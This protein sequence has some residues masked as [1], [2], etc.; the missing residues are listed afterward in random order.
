VTATVTTE[1][2]EFQAETKQL[3]DLV[4]HS[5]YTNKD[6]FLR[7]LISNAS[8]ALD[9]VRFESLTNPD[10]LAESETLE[11]RL[12]T[13]IAARRLSVSDNGIGM[14][15]DE[16]I[17]NIGSIAKS[18]TRELTQKLREAKGGAAPLDLIGN[19]GVG[20]YS[21]FMVAD[22]VVVE[23]VRAGESGATRWESRADGT[24]TIGPG[25]RTTRGTTVT[26]YLKP[27]DPE[28]GIQDYT[29]E[30]TLESIVKRYSDFVNYPIRHKITRERRETDEKGIVKP[31]GTTTIVTDDKTLNSQMPIWV[32]SESEVSEDDYD[33][34]YR[35]ISGDWEKPM[36]RFSYKAE[37]V[38]EYRTL[39]YV[40]ASSPQD[41]YFYNSDFGLRLYAR[42]VL[43]MDRCE[44]LLPRFLRFFRGVVDAADLP[45]NVSRQ[46]LQENRH[47][48]QIRKWL[49]RKAL[50]S[51]AKLQA[52]EPEKYRAFWKEFGR[53]IKEG[54]ATEFQHKDRI[55]DL[56]LF[57][58][59]AD[60]KAMT[61][62][63]EYVG[64][65]KE[66]QEEIYYLSGESRTMC[67]NSPLL[68]G[69]LAKG[70]EVLFLTDGVDE[71]ALQ[72]MPEYEG[73]KLK[74]VA[75]A[76]A[77]LGS[78][79]EKREAEAKLK[80]SSEKLKG[81]TSSLAETL[82]SQ[83]KQVRLSNR[84][85]ESPACL[86]AEEHDMSPQM[87]RLM[88]M[89]QGESAPR[90]RRILELNPSHQIVQRLQARYQAS[91]DDPQIAEYAELLYG[92]AALAEG[93]D[94]PDA[95][96]FNKLLANLMARDA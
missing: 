64:R 63:A 52:D 7:E 90:Q 12:D 31:D 49:T 48:A 40:P 57:E 59:S 68:E 75:K 41:L 37:G 17:S 87:E 30:W 61:T 1:T 14:S 42:R 82:K 65:M 80:E 51:F 6:I 11:I 71:L 91:S 9:R 85:T 3:L 89:S 47:I 22:R 24:Y 26:L 79:A 70:Y 69:F 21:A 10:L 95:A 45:L 35:Q 77:N 76:D 4:I 32:R 5:L 66:G 60:P 13:D 83:V 18:G 74:S 62:F 72:F 81:L 2:R 53:A 28:A 46:M 73:K 43:I 27:P 38:S 88:R 55:A 19:F 96:R 20:F 44:D 29:D 39:L 33:A 58:S 56:M 94:L 16:V 78:A 34:F 86:A 23:T 92:Y 93:L 67:E 54:V 84:L 50:D 8:D 15:R 25:A 36:L